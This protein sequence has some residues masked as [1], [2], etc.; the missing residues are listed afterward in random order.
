MPTLDRPDVTLYYEVSGPQQ[1]IPVVV[2]VGFGAHSHDVLS[3]LLLGLLG[4][5]GYRVLIVDN[6]GSGQTLTQPYADRTFDAMTADILAVMDAEGFQ[7]AHILGISM[8]GCIAHLLAIEQPQ[9]VRSLISCVSLAKAEENSRSAFL[10]E[11]IR[12]LKDARVPQT[13]LN[14][15]STVTSLSEAAFHDTDLIRQWVEAPGDPFSQSRAGWELQIVALRG[16]DLT[17]RLR[18]ITA[19]TLVMSS[20]DDLLVPPHNQRAI[21]ERIADAQWQDWEGGHVFMLEPERLPRFMAALMRFWT[22]VDAV[23]SG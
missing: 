21:H 18:Q 5:A 10:L 12:L 4:Q 20:P 23:R 8:G 14:R 13:L 7:D 6:R 22:Q 1:G 3:K 2:C 19:P 11:T 16:Y 15:I 9:R 17:D